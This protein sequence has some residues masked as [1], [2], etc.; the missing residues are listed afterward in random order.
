MC[1]HWA[2]PKYDTTNVTD[3]TIAPTQA[4]HAD[5][6]G[7]RTR[8][9]NQYAKW[10]NGSNSRRSCWCSCLLPKYQYAKCRNGSLKRLGIM[11]IQPRTN[12]TSWCYTNDW[13]CT[14][15]MMMS[16]GMTMH[17]RNYA[18]KNVPMMSYHMTLHNIISDLMVTY[19][20]KFY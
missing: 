2:I 14:E 17:R 6:L 18:P 13:W 19:P 11:G 20:I 3:V 12:V 1:T 15:G 5:A 8:A 10:R 9:D 4:E 7:V 16:E